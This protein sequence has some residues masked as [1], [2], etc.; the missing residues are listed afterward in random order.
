MTALEFNTKIRDTAGRAGVIEADPEGLMNRLVAAGRTV[1]EV[2]WEEF[3]PLLLPV[4]DDVIFLVEAYEG[5]SSFIRSG[6]E[7]SVVLGDGE[8]HMEVTR[9][10]DVVHVV[11]THVPFLNRALLKKKEYEVSLDSYVEA[12]TRLIHGLVELGGPES[13]G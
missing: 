7:H 9:D 4:E 10:G 8:L 2:S 13:D 1:L 11:C 6:G 12:W 3:G 5:L